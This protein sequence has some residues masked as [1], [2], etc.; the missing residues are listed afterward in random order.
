M[1][2]PTNAMV[3][4]F[5]DGFRCYPRFRRCSRMLCSLTLALSRVLKQTRAVAYKDSPSL[6]ASS[7]Y[8]LN[9]P[10]SFT[11]HHL[12]WW[13]VI[14]QNI[15]SWFLKTFWIKL[16]Q[17]VVVY[18][19][20]FQS[21]LC[22]ILNCASW[23]LEICLLRNLKIVTNFPHMTRTTNKQTAWQGGVI[24]LSFFFFYNTSNIW[25]IFTVL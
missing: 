23:M 10:V 24:G 3:N 14:W 21:A 17:A 25:S 9:K 22:S 18:S 20:A 5:Y 2:N 4:S 11:P 13:W 19:H 1:F 15:L 6:Q 8:S 16:I 12:I 7:L